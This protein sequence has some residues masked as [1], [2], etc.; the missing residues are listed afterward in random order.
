VLELLATSLTNRRI[1]KTLFTTEKTV[2]V[3][4]TR[5]LVKLQVA[6]RSGAGAIAVGI[7]KA[8]FCWCLPQG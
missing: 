6:N 1:A 8:L 7:G 4:V 5:V 2:S 3:H